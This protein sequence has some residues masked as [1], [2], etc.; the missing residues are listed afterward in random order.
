MKLF[1]A[2]QGFVGLADRYGLEWFPVLVEVYYRGPLR[3]D[4]L[5]PEFLPVFD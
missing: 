4:W 3:V 5:S 2:L 1:S